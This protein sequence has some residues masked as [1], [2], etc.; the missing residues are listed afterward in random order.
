MNIV[1]KS[2]P[3]RQQQQQT[4]NKSTSNNN[5][6]KKKKQQQQQPKKARKKKKKTSEM[7]SEERAVD[8]KRGSLKHIFSF[9]QAATLI[10]R[11]LLLNLMPSGK[12]GAQATTFVKMITAR[13]KEDRIGKSV[14]QKDAT[15]NL[16]IVEL[17]KFANSQVDMYVRNPNWEFKV[18]SEQVRNLE[19][20]QLS[21]GEIKPDEARQLMRQQ[22][23]QLRV[24]QLGKDTQNK[25]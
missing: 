10:P 1:S 3:L 5:H 16:G 15:L 18:T 8:A 2:T 20:V 11:M 24:Q 22:Q 25:C 21:S 19:R 4:E 23:E 9:C 6:K 14:P 17:G 13:Q 12:C 7:T